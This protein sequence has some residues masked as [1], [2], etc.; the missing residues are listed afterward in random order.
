MPDLFCK[1][2][3]FRIGANAPKN[4]CFKGTVTAQSIFGGAG[5]YFSYCER[6]AGKENHVKER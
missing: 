5:S 4:S 1:A 2:R 6:Y 3:Y